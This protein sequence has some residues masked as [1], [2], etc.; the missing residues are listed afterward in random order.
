MSETGGLLHA[1]VIF[2]LTAVLMVP[3]AKRLKLGA[4]LGY[5][6]GGVLIG[7]SVLGLISQPESIS[8]L[9]ELGVVMLMFIIGLELSPR[10]LSPH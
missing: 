5:L 1:S 7:P 2:L 3:L 4:V 10:R 6:L 9:S 8:Q